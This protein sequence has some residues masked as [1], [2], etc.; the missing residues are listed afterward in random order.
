M[1]KRVLSIAVNL[2]CVAAIL[3]SLAAGWAV[4]TAQPNRPPTLFG[5]SFMV[6]VSGSMEPTFPVGTLIL[7]REVT[8]DQ[9][10]PGDIITFYGTVGTTTGI[11]TH[12]V[13]AK[14]GDGL[15]ALLH[16]KGDA[17]H[18]QD[19]NPVSR[20]GLIGKVVWQS[21]LL[22]KLVALLR[23]KYVFLAII[24]L[25]LAGVVV[26]NLV[27]LVRLAR[28]EIRAAEAEL[29]EDENDR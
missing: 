23:Q 13:I 28:S 26:A 14:E 22:G 6:V 9:V 4:L 16:T 27:K 20:E 12:R 18:S 19:P 25:P 21:L 7:S 15:G 3:L 5:N 1:L 11:I 29:R 2:L 24:I 10:E 8:P 17:N